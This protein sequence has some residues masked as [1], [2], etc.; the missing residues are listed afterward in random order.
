MAP[1]PTPTIAAMTQRLVEIASAVG[2]EHKEVTLTAVSSA[3][4]MLGTGSGY[5]PM[6]SAM[7]QHPDPVELVRLQWRWWLEEFPYLQGHLDSVTGWMTHPRGGQ[8]R[9]LAQQLT[10]LAQVDLC[11][12]A[13]HP[14]VAGDLLGQVLAEVN[15]PGDRSARGAFY[16]PPAVAMLMAQMGG[17]LE[18]HPSQS[19]HEPCV[20]GGGLV[21]AAVRLCEPQV[22]HPNCASGCCRTSTR[23]LWPSPGSRCPSMASPTCDW[24]AQTRSTRSACP[25]ERD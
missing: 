11:A 8:A 4:L 7:S 21:L 2:C 6:L 23:P 3:A 25:P 12:V 10:Y 18:S 14:S 16:T 5:Q 9:V 22:R 19:I 24:C 15:A 20:G 17:T 1:N 13:E